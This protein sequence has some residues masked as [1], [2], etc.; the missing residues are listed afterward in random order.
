MQSFMARVY[1]GDV[2]PALNQKYYFAPVRQAID[3]K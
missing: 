1:N 3:L 2:S